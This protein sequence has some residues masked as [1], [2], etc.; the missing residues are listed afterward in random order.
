MPNH[1]VRPSHLCRLIQ[2][3]AAGALVLAMAVGVIACGGDDDS[4]GNGSTSTLESTTP[5][6][7]GDFE[8]LSPGVLTIGESFDYPPFETIKDGEPYGFNVDVMREVAK[9]LG[10][11]PKFVKEPWETILTSTAA[12]KFDVMGESAFITPERKQQID[13]SIPYFTTEAVLIVNPEETPDLKAT[14]DLEDGDVVGVLQN[15]FIQPY[16]EDSIATDG[17]QLKLYSDYGDMFNDLAAGRITAGLSERLGSVELLKNR[18]GLEITSA[19]P[20]DPSITGT[21]FG[22]GFAKGTDTNRESINGV[23]EDMM[24]DGTFETLWEQHVPDVPLND[25]Y[26]SS[27]TGS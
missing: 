25:K 17:V 16:A 5:T 8:P 24:E 14:A 19:I 18:P 23:L 6:A 2:R 4:G 1:C 10:L 9:R 26:K 7:S 27:E 21:E 15:S 13:F 3:L 11:K 12:H 20:S 22:Y